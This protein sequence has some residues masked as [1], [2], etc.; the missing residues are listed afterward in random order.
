ME[1]PN[2]MKKGVNFFLNLKTKSRVNHY[3]L[4]VECKYTKSNS[5]WIAGTG[6]W[7]KKTNILK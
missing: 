5:V 2:D 1:K 7:E 6:K 4:I 3:H